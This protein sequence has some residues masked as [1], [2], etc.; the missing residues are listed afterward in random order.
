[1]G[2][3]KADCDLPV[4]GKRKTV[5]KPPQQ[6]ATHGLNPNKHQETFMLLMSVEG[7]VVLVTAEIWIL[8][9][10][11]TGGHKVRRHNYASTHPHARTHTHA[12]IHIHTPKTYS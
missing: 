2:R 11:R 8:V 7:L 9:L 1:M 12:H 5:R 6:K 3:G 4:G 10:R